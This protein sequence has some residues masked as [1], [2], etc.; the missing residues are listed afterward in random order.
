MFVVLKN[1]SRFSNLELFFILLRLFAW[2]SISMY[3]IQIPNFMFLPHFLDIFVRILLLALV[4][5]FFVS[6]SASLF[7]PVALH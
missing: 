1:H 5:S 7:P 4:S 6:D 3:L 2:P